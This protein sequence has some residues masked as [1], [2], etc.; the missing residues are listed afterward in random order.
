VPVLVPTLPVRGLLSGREVG[1][2]SVS[3]FERSL[4]VGFKVD[5]RNLRERRKKTRRRTRRKRVSRRI[6][7]EAAFDE[8]V[9]SRERGVEMV[10]EGCTMSMLW[11]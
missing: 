10:S 4:S 6:G 7:E 9:F 11:L 3:G 8:R 1:G 5:K 2:R